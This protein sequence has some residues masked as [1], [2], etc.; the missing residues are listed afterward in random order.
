MANPLTS[1]ASVN[2]VLATSDGADCAPAG[3]WVYG[4]GVYR[5]FGTGNASAYRPRG[6]LRFD[7]R[8]GSPAPSSLRVEIGAFLGSANPWVDLD[9][10]DYSSGAF[11]TVSV[12]VASFDPDPTASMNLPFLLHAGFSSAP[13]AGQTLFYVD[14]IRWTGD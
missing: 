9:P 2:A 12:P 5:T 4:F 7:L 6:H 13:T 1:S 14:N 8:L 11:T 10:G 3:P